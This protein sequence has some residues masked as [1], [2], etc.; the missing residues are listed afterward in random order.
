MI[1]DDDDDDVDNDCGEIGGKR[2]DRGNLS[3]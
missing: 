1:D 2:I 3:T